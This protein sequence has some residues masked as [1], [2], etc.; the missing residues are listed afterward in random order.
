MKKIAPIVLCFTMLS[1]LAVAAGAQ[2][3]TTTTTQQTTPDGMTT[4][5]S[6]TYNDTKCGA[7]QGDTWVANPDCTDAA[8]IRHERLAG[9]II[10]VKGHLVTIQQTD[11]TVVINDQPALMNQDTGRVA[12]GRAIVAHGYWNGGTFFATLLTTSDPAM[13]HSM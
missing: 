8:T 7:W 5:V 2:Q 6:R 11:K 9:T 3:S 10:A 13:N 1:G 4:T 12:V